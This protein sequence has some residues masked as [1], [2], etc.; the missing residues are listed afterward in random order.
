MLQVVEVVAGLRPLQQTL[1]RRRVDDGAVLDELCCEVTRAGC[2]I[3]GIDVSPSGRWLV[4][5]RNSGQGEWGY[6]VL[7][8]HPLRRASGVAEERGY[9]LELPRFSDDETVLV[10]GAGRGYLGGW[11]AHPDDEVDDPLRGV[12]VSPGF[13]F[14]HRLADHRETR[15]ALRVELP[16]GWRPDDPWAE[17]YGPHDVTP[18]DEGVRM[19][20]SWGVT[21]EVKA[22]L[23]EVIVLPVPHPSGKGAW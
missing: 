5:R 3:E 6:D 8:T 1:R 21:V 7:T 23:P 17:W 10:G 13:V 16:P 11:W 4:T 19:V 22:P 9:L 15:H 12:P 20:T 18:T 2:A 14:V